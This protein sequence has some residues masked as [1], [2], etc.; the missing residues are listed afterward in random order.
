M[1]P[2]SNAT[3]GTESPERQPTHPDAWTLEFLVGSEYIPLITAAFDQDKSGFVRITE[4]NALT[5]LMPPNFTL[6]QWCAFE[7]CGTHFDNDGHQRS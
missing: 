2:H 5:R 7:A 3:D 6:A 4:A 1:N